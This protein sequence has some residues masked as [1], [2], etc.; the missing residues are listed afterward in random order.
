[1]KKVKV[2]VAQ[3]CPTL[4]DSMDS[5]VHGILH[6]RILEW[7]AIPSPGE[8]PNPGIEPSLLHCRRFLYQLSHQGSPQ[9]V[10]NFFF[11]RLYH[12]ACGILVLGPGIEPVPSVLGMQHLKHWMAR[13]VLLKV[14]R[15]CCLVAQ[16][17][18]TLLRHHEQ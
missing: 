10:S 16:S 3:A 12:A 2:K 18:L 15:C 9:D 1:M 8:L 14:L 4:F 7:V 6:T 13:E 5:I 11:L 17:C